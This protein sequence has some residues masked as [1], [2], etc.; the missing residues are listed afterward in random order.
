VFKSQIPCK[1]IIFLVNMLEKDKMVNKKDKLLYLETGSKKIDALLGGGIPYGIVTTV[2]SE[3]ML[4]KSLFGYQGGLGNIKK[5]G[6]KTLLIDTEGIREY[7]LFNLLN[8]FRLRWEL[9]EKIVRDNF[10]VINTQQDKQMQSIQKL[11]QMFGYM[12]KLE[13][14]DNGKY[15]VT[16]NYCEATLKEKE[17]EG[18]SMIIIDSLT[19]PV[20]DSVGSETSNLPARAQLIERLFGKL[21]HIAQVYN[22]A[23]IVLHHAV[24]NPITPFGKDLGNPYGGNPILYN[25]KYILQFIGSN[26]AVRDETGFGIECRRV[27]LIRSP[28]RQSTGE[29]IPI[30]LKNN[31]GFTDE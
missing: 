13:L 15:K 17:L 11:M 20:K 7:D 21:Y 5:T 6:K 25:S 19:K 22:I 14:S 29:M 3:P 26:K 10:M 8:K 18:I 12:V 24:V 30:R 4:G 23:V 31:V 2:F 28:D 16:F 27:R 1:H 9:D